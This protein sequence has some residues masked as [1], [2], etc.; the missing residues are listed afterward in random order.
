MS[1]SAHRMSFADAGRTRQRGA[2]PKSGAAGVSSAEETEQPAA[3]GA[4]TPLWGTDS[5][6]DDGPALEPEP[7]SEPESEPALE[8][9][10]E[11]AAEDVEVA[12]SEGVPPG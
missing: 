8:P 10:P 12:I 3:L 11:P 4:P 9:E 6:S 5:D 2:G 7:E 1:E